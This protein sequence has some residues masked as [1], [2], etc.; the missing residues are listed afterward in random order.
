MRDL[1]DEVLNA[2]CGDQRRDE[3]KSDDSELHFRLN[4]EVSELLIKAKA[5][6]RDVCKMREKQA[7]NE[8]FLTR[9]CAWKKE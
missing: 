9:G 7:K 2:V 6:D 4:L 5:I 8:C 1:R 3:R